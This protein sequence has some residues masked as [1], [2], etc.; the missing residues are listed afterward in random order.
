MSP[1]RGL[2]LKVLGCFVVLARSAWDACVGPA[3]SQVENACG[4]H[5]ELTAAHAARVAG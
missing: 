5:C 1:R 3:F 4:T 2:Q